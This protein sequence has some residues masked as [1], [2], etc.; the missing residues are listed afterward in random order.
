MH[1]ERADRATGPTEECPGPDETAPDWEEVHALIQRILAG[2][3]PDLAPGEP[4]VRSPGGRTSG[5]AFFLASYRTFTPALPEDHEA[6]VAGVT[7]LPRSHG[8]LVRADLCGEETGQLFWEM[9]QE[10]PLTRTAVLHA[11]EQAASRLR[12]QGNLVGRALTDIG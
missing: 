11:A 4:P 12:N 7:L 1:P 9:E 3:Q 5:P 6:V 2:L 8:V 10:I